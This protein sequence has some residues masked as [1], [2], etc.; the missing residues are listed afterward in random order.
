MRLPFKIDVRNEIPRFRAETFRTKEPETIQWINN[1]LRSDSRVRLFVDVGANTGI[2]SLYAA[3]VNANVEILAAEPIGK[4]FIEL[5]NNID[6]NHWAD[7]IKA[8]NVAIS[9]ADGNG[10][11][12]RIDDRVGSSGAQ[13][14]NGSEGEGVVVSV[15]TGDQ[16][17]INYASSET[18]TI[19]SVM[20]KI[21]TDGNELDVLRGFNN[22]FAKGTICTVLVETN[23]LNADAIE[24]FLVSW[25]LLEDNDYHNIVD[26]SD[27][28]RFLYGNVERTKIYS[29]VL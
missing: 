4:S 8:L 7:R 28:R 3:S 17:V 24:Q 14:E 5:R 19:N 11:M 2:Y 23:P 1:N 26:H 25:N 16:L 22:M 18:L 6:L 13:L 27:H 10:R 29:T 9:D 15:A 12:T 20:L 21:D